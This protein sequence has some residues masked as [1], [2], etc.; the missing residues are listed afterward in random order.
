[1]ADEFSN[2]QRKQPVSQDR[3]PYEAKWRA[4]HLGNVR[5]GGKGENPYHKEAQRDKI[6]FR[7]I[8]LS[9]V[10]LVA[11]AVLWYFLVVSH[12]DTESGR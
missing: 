11:A 3:K 2:W 8:I 10:I 1:M 5:S 9:L 7:I 4:S 12:W 6:I